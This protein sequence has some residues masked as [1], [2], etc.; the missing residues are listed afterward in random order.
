MESTKILVIKNFIYKIIGTVILTF[1]LSCQCYQSNATIGLHPEK[2]N[3]ESSLMHPENEQITL[4]KLISDTVKLQ[5]ENKK[6]KLVLSLKD[7]GVTKLANYRL[8][9]RTSSR[10]SEI[11]YTDV[12]QIS[13]EESAIDN[14]LNNFTEKSTLSQE[15][16]PLSIVFE[17]QVLPK[18]LETNVSIELYYNNVVKPI[19]KISIDWKATIITDAMIN[20]AEQ[21]G[22]LILAGVLKKLQKDLSVDINATNSSY[23]NET[24]LHEAVTLE[25]ID[26]ISVLIER[27]ANINL[28]NNYGN[29]PIFRA[30]RNDNINIINLL[31]SNGAD[32]QI[33]NEDG[34]TPLYTAVCFSKNET[35][36]LLLE[37][38]PLSVN[39][40]NNQQD[41]CL[42]RA[43]YRGN[44]EI[45][46]TV[47][48]KITAL[49]TLD[50]NGD[51]PLH[52]AVSLDQIT[53]TQVLLKKEIQKNILNKDNKNPIDLVRSEEMRQKLSNQ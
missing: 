39:L 32:L 35:V 15:D 22:A 30:V 44:L 4:L 13:H 9:I 26:I 53:M 27:G 17:L 14:L 18:I 31:L 38:N 2:L 50:G 8:V 1:S 51:T 28:K 45:F 37:A 34:N 21:K 11:R 40:Q 12:N 29:T 6:F 52:V 33:T 10:D 3:R 36:S 48:A 49:N 23:Y 7:T 5:G 25:N 47:I 42:H 24:A 41:S 20:L 46:N 16:S 19:Q 43:I